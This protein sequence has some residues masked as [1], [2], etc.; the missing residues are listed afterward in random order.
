MIFSWLNLV[1]WILVYLYD[2]LLCRDYKEGVRFL[3]FE[4]K[5][6]NSK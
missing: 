1:E 4:I 2:R 3:W 6:L 5:I